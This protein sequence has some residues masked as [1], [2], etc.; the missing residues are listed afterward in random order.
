MGNKILS[1]YRKITPTEKLPESIESSKFA[2]HRGRMLREF[3][4]RTY[5]HSTKFERSPPTLDF[6][7]FCDSE[8][9]GL[10]PFDNMA[11]ALS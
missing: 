8:L 10:H 11:I 9:T 1:D 2:S 6:R 5:S 7:E 4:S 3:H